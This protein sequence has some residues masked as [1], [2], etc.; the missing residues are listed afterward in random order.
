[1][2]RVVVTGLG[3]VTPLGASVKSSW[4][5]LIEGQ[6]GVARI[7]TVDVHDLPSRIAGI[8]PRGSADGELDPDAHV[9]PAEQRRIGDF[10]LYALAAAREAIEDAGAQAFEDHDRERTGVAIGSGIG[11]LPFIEESV[12][13]LRDHGPRRVSPFFIPGALVNEASAA[14]SIRYGFRGPNH[15]VATACSTGSHAIG[16]AARMIALDDADVMIAGGTEAAIGRLTLA[17]FSVMRALSTSFNDDPTAASRPWDVDRDG[18][19]LG[20]GAGI[21]VLEEREHARRRGATIYGEVLGYGLS[22]DAHHVAAPAPDGRG[23][24]AAMRAALKRAQL[25]PSDIDYVCAHAT[26]TP[27]GDP[28]ELRAVRSVF[29]A[30]A[31]RISMSATKAATGHLLGAAGAVQAVFSLLA[32]RDQ[33]V[34]PTANLARPSEG[35]DLDLVPHVAKKRAVRHVLSNSFA[36]GGANATLVFG[37]G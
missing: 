22:G 35:C 37:P 36:F 30:A 15:A 17:S 4:A 25:D 6:S 24:I 14:I 7:T 16:D 31:E 28:I 8:V 5:R 13:R 21:V 32:L 9:T 19:V 23:A 33:L 11:G 27:A 29:G 2:R 18:F 10:I 1:M 12:M 34:P 20:E 26:S 3:L